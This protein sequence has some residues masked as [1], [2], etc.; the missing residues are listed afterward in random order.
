MQKTPKKTKKAA[1]I[2]RR[3]TIRV[4]G[5]RELGSVGGGDSGAVCT[6]T[7]IITGLCV[8]GAA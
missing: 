8:P 1:L 2:V 4:L 7:V 6:A 3:D 5:E